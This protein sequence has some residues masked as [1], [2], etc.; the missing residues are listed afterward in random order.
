MNQIAMR[1]LGC[2]IILITVAQC[3]LAPEKPRS[4]PALSFLY[5]PEPSHR[6]VLFVHGVFGDPSLSWTNISGRTWPQLMRADDRFRDFDLAMY[7]FDSPVRERTSTSQEIGTRMLSQLEDS[8]IFRK[9]SEIYFIAHS[10]GGLVIKRL[11]VNLYRPGQVEKLRQIKAVLYISTPA[12]GADLAELGRLLSNNPQFG[13]MRLA[14]SNSYLQNLEDE[15]GILMRE[16]GAEMFPRSFCAYE[17]KPT[18]GTMIVTRIH[19]VT[20]CDHNAVAFD[21]DHISIAKPLDT[22]S[23]VYEWARARIEEAR[24]FARKGSRPM[25]SLVVGQPADPVFWIYNGSGNVVQQPKYQLNLWNLSMADPD[26]REPRFNMQIPVRLMQDYILAGKALGPWRILDL[27]ARGRQ[28]TPGQVLFG[29]GQLQCLN[30][31]GI[32]Y[33]WLLLKIGESG[34]IAEVPPAEVKMINTRLTAVLRA[35]DMALS[36]VDQVIPFTSREIVPTVHFP[37]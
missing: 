32:R 3:S 25:V 2:V 21:E 36:T 4:L 28:I 18:Y 10:M 26:G 19:A 9:Y 5:A 15:W 34:W 27:S 14:D 8:G 7:R 6:L 11:L 37:Q 16:R 33:F 12:Q 23:A 30:C 24:D 29:Y 22:Q 1:I 17:T 13:D 20:S 35:R 31:E